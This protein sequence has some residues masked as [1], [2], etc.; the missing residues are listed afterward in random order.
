MPHMW[1]FWK[2]WAASIPF[3]HGHLSQHCVGMQIYAP[4]LGSSPSQNI[5]K[6]QHGVTCLTLS[7]EGMLKASMHD[8]CPLKP[9]SMHTRHVHNQHLSRIA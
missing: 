2:G 3:A 6:R 5:G 1:D 4:C 7:P 8:T 9:P